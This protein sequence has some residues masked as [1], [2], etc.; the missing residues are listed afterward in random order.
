MKWLKKTFF[1]LKSTFF[2]NINNMST[3]ELKKL[4]ISKIDDI[5]DVE[6]LKVAYKLLEY[7]SKKEGIYQIS[8][9]EKIDIDL[10]LEQIKEGLVISDEEIQ[11][12]ID[13]WLEK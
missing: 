11:I 4:L 9:E 10:G 12:E 13:K 5:N 7:G 6:L 3:L 2:K 1:K 8:D